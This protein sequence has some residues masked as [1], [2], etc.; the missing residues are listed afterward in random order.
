[1]PRA[2]AKLILGDILAEHSSCTYEAIDCI[3]FTGKGIRDA[4]L[5]PK[6]QWRVHSSFTCGGRKLLCLL[7]KDLAA[8]R[9]PACHPSKHRIPL[10]W[11]LPPASYTAA[12]HTGNKVTF[13]KTLSCPSQ[14]KFSCNVNRGNDAGT[15]TLQ[16]IS[17]PQY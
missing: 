9:H 6:L 5:D 7:P 1:M 12:L 8:V 10:L 17:R 16:L 2:Q 14:N 13:F 11:L 3:C 4:A 15:W